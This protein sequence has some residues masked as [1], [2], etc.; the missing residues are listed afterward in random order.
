MTSWSS[1]SA[2]IL[3]LI[4]RFGGAGHVFAV[5]MDSYDYQYALS[6]I[7]P[8]I[9]AAHEEKGGMMVL[10]PDS[11]DPVDCVLQAL[12]AGEKVFGADMNSK[13]FKVIRRMSVIQGDGINIDMI[14]KIQTAVIQ[15]GFSVQCV[16]YGMGQTT[17]QSI[18]I[19]QHSIYILLCPLTVLLFCSPCCCCSSSC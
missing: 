8:T 7:L 4:D 15:Q 10:R 12:L 5:V 18:R 2:A 9:A 1:E 6:A 3:H 17:E 13:G 16:S 19:Q 14:D 11:G